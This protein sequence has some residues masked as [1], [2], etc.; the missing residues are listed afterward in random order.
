MP[1]K[2]NRFKENRGG[3]GFGVLDRTDRDFLTP[4]FDAERQR[5]EMYV[6]GLATADKPG[7]VNK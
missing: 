6:G 2:T 3:R 4:E 1:S 5:G 7:V